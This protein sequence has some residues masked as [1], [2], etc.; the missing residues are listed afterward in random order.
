MCSEALMFLYDGVAVLPWMPCGTDE[1]GEA[2][3]EKL[4]DRRA[5]VWAQHGVFGTGASPDEALGLIEI[6]DKAAELYLKTA[7]LPRLSVITDENLRTLARA[8]DVTP[9]ADYL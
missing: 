3:A 4:R 8:L 2:T 9:R 5:V 6:I 7:H 1:I